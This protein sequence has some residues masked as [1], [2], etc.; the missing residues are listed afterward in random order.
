MRRG[1]WPF[2]MALAFLLACGNDSKGPSVD[3]YA[4]ARA[5]RFLH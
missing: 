2:W 4:K 5:S 3:D 1:V